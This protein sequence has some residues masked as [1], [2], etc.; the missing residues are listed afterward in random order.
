MTNPDMSRDLVLALD[1]GTGGGRAV[2]VSADG[3]VRSRSYHAWSFFEPPGLEVVGREFDP[4]R[5][6]DLLAQCAREAIAAAGGS[7]AGVVVTGQR[8][9]CVFLDRNGAPLYGGP[10]HDARGINYTDEIESR[11]GE[12]RVR[13]IAGRWP[14]WI[15]LPAR[16]AWFRRQRPEVFD[17][18]HRILMIPDWVG[19]LL[20]GRAATEPST[21]AD[22][23]L[24]DVTRRDWSDELIAA[25]GIARS[26]LPEL[27]SMGQRLGGVTAEAA[28]RF[29][30]PAGTPV[31]VGAAD[32][33]AAMIAANAFVP[34]DV[35]IVAGATAPVMAV[36]S[37]PRIDPGRKHWTGCHPQPGL[38]LIESNAGD[39][40]SAWRNYVE[41]H[42][43]LMATD[44]PALYARVEELAAA[45][46]VG[47]GG[48]R[49]FMGPII[50]DL[51][52]ITPC[53]RAGMLTTFP[54]G[55][56]NSGP[57]A[58]ARAILE[59]IAFALRANLEQVEATAGRANTV[60]LAGGMTRSRL[61]CSIV[62]EVLGREIRVVTEPEA[63]ALGCAVVGFTALGVHQNLHLARRAMIRY[64]LKLTPDNFTADDYTCLYDEWREEYARMM[65][66]EDK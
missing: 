21:A 56:D 46:G 63:T 7:V 25:T 39:T 41:G 66:Q 38:W 28:A 20:T 14:P 8:Q 13:R 50:W 26:L 15:F 44:L 64:P 40:G 2:A 51:S 54:P 52:A 43:G 10:N 57:G 49:A 9:G 11:L 65:G 6:R 45:A 53:G 62:C 16:L 55:P 61:F 60:S 19:W 4:D 58:F 23:M 17:R 48:A 31:F 36:M 37:E 3:E 12:D 30:L 29:G 24:F 5:F 18:I 1:A 33:Q 22:S 47:A 42:L 27:S 32:T 59:N 35:C 34:G